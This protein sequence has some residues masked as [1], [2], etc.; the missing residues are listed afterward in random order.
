MVG[1]NQQE[2]GESY[3]KFYFFIKFN[4]SHTYIPLLVE[5]IPL[6]KHFLNFYSLKE[7]YFV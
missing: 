2:I 7:N 5:M 3:S 1:V 6:V 4:S